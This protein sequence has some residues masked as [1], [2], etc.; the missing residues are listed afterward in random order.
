MSD[1]S[2][3]VARFSI[4][5]LEDAD[6]RL[7][8]LLR[9]HD[10]PLG[11]DKWGFPAGHIENGESA[12]DCARREL[13]EEIG[14]AHVVTELR[15]LGPLRD[16]LWGGIYELHLFHY[17][18]HRGTVTLN[19]EHVDHAWL[20]PG[21]HLALPVMDGIDEDIRLLGVWPLEKLNAAKL[22]AALGGDAR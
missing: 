11:P 12:E 3:P 2:P 7:L 17:R 21:E 15:R 16:T 1:T 18:W 14:A 8:F 5:V 6:S 22:P 10:R 13:C 9:S 4:C 19:H 20:G